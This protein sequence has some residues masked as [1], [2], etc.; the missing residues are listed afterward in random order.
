ALSKISDRFGN[1]LTVQYSVTGNAALGQ[2]YEQLPQT[3]QYTGTEDNSLPPRRTVSFEYEIRCDKS[4][5]CDVPTMFVSGLRLQ[6]KHRLKKLVLSAPNPTDTQPIK[7]YNFAYTQSGASGRSLLA[8][9]SEC[10]GSSVC[11]TPT[12]FSYSDT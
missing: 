11:L 5:R 7:S 6:T 4:A 8:Q 2:G 1:N 3:I 9:I 10:D 12:T